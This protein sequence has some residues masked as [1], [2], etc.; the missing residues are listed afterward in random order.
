MR[1]RVNRPV[2][3]NRRLANRAVNRAFLQRALSVAIYISS[4]EHGYIYIKISVIGKRPF[5][6][7]QLKRHHLYRSLQSLHVTVVAGR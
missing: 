6:L 3:A 1:H 4:F 2:R 5:G 7:C